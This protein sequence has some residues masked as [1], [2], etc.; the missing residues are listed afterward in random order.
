MFL[1]AE[2]WYAVL[3]GLQQP[4]CDVTHVRLF[5]NTAQHVVDLL[6]ALQGTSCSAT[7]TLTRLFIGDLD[8][9]GAQA[10]SAFLAHRLCGVKELELQQLSSPTATAQALAPGLHTAT[11][12]QS[13][14]VQRCEDD[15][16]LATLAGALTSRATTFNRFPLRL[17]LQRCRVAVGAAAALGTL[18]G[19]GGVVGLALAS[20]RVS[21]A[22]LQQLCS[23]AAEQHVQQLC[24]NLPLQHLDLSGNALGPA[25]AETLC[26]ALPLMPSLQSLVLADNSS[27]GN[28]GISRLAPCVAACKSLVHLDLSGCGMCCSGIECLVGCLFSTNGSTP[29][30][31]ME[32]LILD[33]NAID[34]PGFAAVGAALACSGCGLR[35]LSA[36][37]CQISGTA[38]AALPVTQQVAQVPPEGGGA[39]LQV[40]RLGSNP[41]GDKGLSWVVD[42]LLGGS[43][44]NSAPRGRALVELDLS[45]AGLC[46]TGGQCRMLGGGVADLGV[47]Q[48]PLQMQRI[49]SM[50]ALSS[51]SACPMLFHNTKL[52]M[53]LCAGADALVGV[54]SRSPKLHTLRV[55]ANCFRDRGAARLC[56]AV[57]QHPSLR[58]FRADSCHSV[59]ECMQQSL[60][61]ICSR[62][63]CLGHGRQAS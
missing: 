17:T 10:L 1:S 52:Q 49:P 55:A 3:Q 40:L 15:V 56:S 31:R 48:A 59:G 7:S 62:W 61:C 53:L 51:W 32:R 30:S 43:H 13:M 33:R 37:A 14:H 12:L 44:G 34:A 45:S 29:K 35:Q 47:V 23:Q 20:C 63:V 57:A 9:V 41:L 4:D 21:D 24:L 28:Q 54:L 50:P 5:H 19:C 6:S 27:L 22:A 39:A 58:C 25:A 36:E 60:M 18:V 26:A 42:A 2:R 11:S 8:P 16:A 38:L 46:D